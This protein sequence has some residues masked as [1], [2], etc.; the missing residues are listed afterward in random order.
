MYVHI[1][2]EMYH[3]P[4]LDKHLIT[5]DSPHPRIGRP[6]VPPSNHIA[7]TEINTGSQLR[8]GQN[9]TKHQPIAIISTSS[10]HAQIPNASIPTPATFAPVLM[11]NSTALDV[12][13]KPGNIQA[14]VFD[15]QF[16]PLPTNIVS[17][18]NLQNLRIALQNY[19]Y[20]NLTNFILNG[21]QFGFDIGF[22]GSIVYTKPSN[23]LSARQN[24]EAVHKAISKEL[25]RAIHQAPS[26]I[27]HFHYIVPH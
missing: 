4:T 27:H 5:S 2:P 6:F 9:R 23:L 16:N 7:T 10:E 18:I 3:H 15:F 19:P 14:N 25:S 8:L 26:M 1:P 24:P 21:F 22:S 17:P 12:L 11:A 20:A 13:S